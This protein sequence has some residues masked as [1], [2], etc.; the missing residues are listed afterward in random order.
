MRA[1]TISSLCLALA[2]C[3]GAPPIDSDGSLTNDAIAPMMDGASP[4]ADSSAND[5]DADALAA[6]PTLARDLAVSEVAVFQGVRVGL[7]ANDALVANRNAPLVAGRAAAVRAYVAPTAGFTARN[8]TAE[9]LWEESPGAITTLR[10]TRMISA[11]SR[12]SD[13][14]S[15]FTFQI[16]AARVRPTSRWSIR[17]LDPTGAAPAA[18]SLSR[19]PRDGALAPLAPSSAPGAVRVTLVPVRWTRDG[20]NRLPDTSADQL[21]RMRSLLIALYP[22]TAVEFTIHAPIDFGTTTFTGNVNF[23]SLNAVLET[24]RDREM[25]ADDV[26]YYALVAPDVS[27]AAYC[28]RSC[29]TGQSYVV[30]NIGDAS[31]RVGSGVGFTGDDTAWT[32]A[33]ELGHLFGREHAPCSTSGADARYP[34]RGAALGVWGWDARDNTF[35][36]PTMTTDFMGYCDPQWVSDYTYRALYERASTLRPGPMALTSNEPNPLVHVATLFDD[37]AL[38]YSHSRRPKSLP[39]GSATLE[40]RYFDERD[41]LLGAAVASLVEIADGEPGSSANLFVPDAF[42]RATRVE[43]RAQDGARFTL[44]LPSR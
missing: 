36:E 11:A 26:Y 43:L 7:F 27:L 28:G 23:G 9:L 19:A 29:V 20:S 31:I 4:A 3:A 8:V 30:S 13:P 6:N 18:T 5:A 14:N 37:R 38:R 17:L 41:A 10:E 16:D 42:A 34:Y 22:I 15:V 1:L 44:A 39:Q 33:H 21:Q 24:L 32:F 12:E 2:A 40:A 35:F 25:P